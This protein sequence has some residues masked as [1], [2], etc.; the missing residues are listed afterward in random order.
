[1]DGMMLGQKDAWIEKL[2]LLAKQN[3]E[4]GHTDTWL[5]GCLCPISSTEAARECL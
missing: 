3:I 2:R 1:M 4:L 5:H